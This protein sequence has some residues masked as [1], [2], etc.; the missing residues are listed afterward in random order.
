MGHVSSCSSHGDAGAV[1][2]GG[3]GSRQ[4]LGG[5]RCRRL[6]RLTAVALAEVGGHAL[7]MVGVLGASWGGAKAGHRGGLST[8]AEPFSFQQ[9]DASK[10]RPQAVDNSWVMH[11][12]PKRAPSQ[13]LSGRVH[14]SL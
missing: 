3:L 8:P 11:L 5:P 12:S 1:S 13:V 9:P 6:R 2:A 10:R 4:P 7:H 14:R